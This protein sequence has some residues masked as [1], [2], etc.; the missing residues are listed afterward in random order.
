MDL[1]ALHS[2]S[3]YLQVLVILLVIGG[4]IAYGIVE[5]RR[6]RE[7]E[8]RWMKQL[9]NVA[10]LTWR[11]ARASDRRGPPDEPGPSSRLPRRR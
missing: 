7:I 4:A 9:W 6:R 11:S 3:T 8:M 5:G 2:L 1:L 10:V